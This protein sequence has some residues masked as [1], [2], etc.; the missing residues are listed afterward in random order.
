M[1][2]L[3]IINQLKWALQALSLE[4]EEQISSFPEFVV[5]TDELLLEFDNWYDVVIKNYSDSFTTN[6]IEILTKIWLFT[7]NLP[8]T[9]I[10]LS[11][12]EELLFSD[13]WRELR[14][15]SSQALLMLNWTNEI[16]PNERA[17]YIKG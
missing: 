5:V 8:K 11:E 12:K 16:P 17:T 10:Y 15:M 7:D 1:N 13:F 2:E 14:K 3:E 6:Q 9:S 4:A